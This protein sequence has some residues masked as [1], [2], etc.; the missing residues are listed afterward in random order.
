MI[1]SIINIFIINFIVGISCLS[2]GKFFL[3]RFNLGKSF[4]IALITGVIVLSQ[5]SLILNFIFPINKFITFTLIPLFVI[6]FFLQK[7]I[8]KELFK[9]ILISIFSIFF[10]YAGN[11]AEDYSLYHLTNLQAITN[12]KIILGLAHIKLNLGQSPIAFY[13]DAIFQ[14]LPFIKYN[15]NYL[16]FISFA[17]VLFFIYDLLKNTKVFKFCDYFLLISVIYFTLKFSRLGAHGAD[18]ISTA[19]IILG[20]FF[21]LKINFKNIKESSNYHSILISTLFISNAYFFKIFSI[22]YYILLLIII[23]FLIKKKYLKKYYNFI[24]LII[25]LNFAFFLK[26]ILI[27]GCMIFPIAETCFDE[28][29]WG[30]GKPSIYNWKLI[31]EAWT[32]GWYNNFEL[33]YDEYIL[34]FN[35][36][37]TWLN[38]HFI[39]SLEK[40]LIPIT[41]IIILIK[42]LRKNLHHEYEYNLNIIFIFFVTLISSIIWFSNSPL[43][44]LGLNALLPMIIILTNYR[45]LKNINFEL[46]NKHIIIILILLPTF[47]LSKNIIRILN[48][49]KN[50][51]NYPYPRI[52][53]DEIKIINKNKIK[54]LSENDINYYL[55]NGDKC[56][57]VKFPCLTTNTKKKFIFYKKNDYLILKKLKKND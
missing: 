4:P 53:K 40:F 55:Y 9:L 21:F 33:N 20:L 27:S 47:F 38:N 39:K 7:K 19:L 51:E 11:N 41:F 8:K 15:F 32:K 3:C 36:L 23:F 5:L 29:S 18:F 28:F 43:I 22:T 31:N 42:I 45:F 48:T 6:Y 26:N 44:R 52:N 1:G 24:I 17:A 56:F 2:S 12:H 54:R 35:W 30:I 46:L 14:N 49:S 13:G 25:I 16:S 50:Y 34:N 57:I 37:N 10:Y